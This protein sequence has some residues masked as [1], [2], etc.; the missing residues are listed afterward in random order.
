MTIKSRISLYISIVFT[1]L[2]MIIAGIII[3]LFANFRKQEFKERLNEKAMTTIRLLLEVKEVDNDMLKIIDQ[4]TI[5]RLYNEK[6]LIFDSGY[7]LIYS[8]LDDTKINWNKEDLKYLKNNQ[9]FFRSDGDNEIYGIFY[10]S[11]NVDYYALVSANDNFGKRKLNFL[12]WLLI[13]AGI[14]FTICTWMLTFMVVKKQLIPLTHFQKK[15]KNINDLNIE[16][17]LDD[18]SQTNHEIALLSKEFNF[19]MNRITEVYHKQ[20][21][22]TSQASHELRTPLARISAQL[23]NC[24]Q[25]ATPNEIGTLRSIF[26][27]ITQLNE[28]INSLLILSKIEGKT[29]ERNE[30]TRIDEIIY[31]SIGKIVRI[32]PDFKVSFNIRDHDEPDNFLEITA[33][34]GL[35]EIVF[36]NLLRNAYLYSDDKSVFIQISTSDHHLI[37]ELTNN[38]QSLNAD[39]QKKLFTPFMRGEHSRHIPGS[40]LGLRMVYRILTNYHYGI[41]YKG[42]GNQNTFILTFPREK[43]HEH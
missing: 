26:N 11:N 25:H 42:A 6:T 8:S 9:E 21:E 18:E 31:N 4:N 35:L 22:F 36:T 5:N 38:G 20:K 43:D 33:N 19:M 34:Q 23:E 7:N 30:S 28:L 13:G 39:E 27:D 16:M 24:I 12:I 32:Y 15:I 1:I 2:F 29:A 40:G 14:V 10:D 3:S 37:V 41:E 17:P